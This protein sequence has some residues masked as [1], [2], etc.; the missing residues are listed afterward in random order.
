MYFESWVLGLAQVYHY[1][2]VVTLIAPYST[3]T[4]S[5]TI[6]NATK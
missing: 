6:Y 1:I 4:L 2:D 5:F 3:L